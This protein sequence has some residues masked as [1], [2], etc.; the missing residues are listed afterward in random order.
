M[1]NNTLL[2]RSDLINKGSRTQIRWYWQILVHVSG[3]ISTRQEEE[4][5]IHMVA[6]LVQ[7]YCRSK[8]Q[9]RSYMDKEYF[10]ILEEY[11][12]VLHIYNGQNQYILHQTISSK[13]HLIFKLSHHQIKLEKSY[14]HKC[15]LNLLPPTS[16]SKA[17]YNIGKKTTSKKK[18]KR[19]RANTDWEDPTMYVYIYILGYESISLKLK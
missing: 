14:L 19:K 12:Q 9:K 17:T 1:Y 13:D 8:N 18:K 10:Y 15:G 2:W 7:I 3:K 4:W 11:L 5:W 6:R 16:G